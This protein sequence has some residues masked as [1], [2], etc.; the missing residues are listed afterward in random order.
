M[1]AD[2][3]N[4]ASGGTADQSRPSKGHG[5]IAARQIL[6][7][8]PIRLVPAVIAVTIRGLPI[9]LRPHFDV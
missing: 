8:M 7:N 1:Q 4:S 2:L 5:K 6:R 9:V 3:T